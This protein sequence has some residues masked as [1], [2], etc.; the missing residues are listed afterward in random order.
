MN[1]ASR[2]R[3][4]GSGRRA[5]PG[6]NSGRLLIDAGMCVRFRWY[7]RKSRNGSRRL[8][9]R[10]SPPAAER[11]I[12]LAQTLVALPAV[13]EGCWRAGEGRSRSPSRAGG[14]AMIG[15]PPWRWRPL[16][17]LCGLRRRR[18]PP[19]TAAR[20]PRRPRR[21]GRRP[22]LCHRRARRSRPGDAPRRR[23]APPSRRADR[24]FRAQGRRPGARSDPRRRLLDPDL[25]PDRRAAGPGLCGLAEKLCRRRAGQCR[26]PCAQIAASPALSPMSASRC[27]RP[28][29]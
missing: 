9:C 8:T 20:R 19:K 2:E 28:R 17:A 5:R 12:S 29:S 14:Q 26:A 27:S 13:A 23:R 25:Q 1:G 24:L 22:G 3:V 18:A 11:T 15:S 6:A 21:S 4:C 16:L 10:R 7:I